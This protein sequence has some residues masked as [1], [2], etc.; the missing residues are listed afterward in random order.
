ME[1]DEIQSFSLLNPSF[2]RGFEII[3]CFSTIHSQS[4]IIVCFF[5]KELGYRISTNCSMIKSS[6]DTTWSVSAPLLGLPCRSQHIKKGPS[7][8]FFGNIDVLN[9]SQRLTLVPRQTFLRYKNFHIHPHVPDA[10]E[11]PTL[12]G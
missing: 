8:F 12:K 10:S 5:T 3:A 6:P 9:M 4:E 11:S 1:L 7:L 2:E